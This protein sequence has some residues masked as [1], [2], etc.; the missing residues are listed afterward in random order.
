M[1]WKKLILAVA[2]T[3]FFLAEGDALAQYYSGHSFGIRL[4]NEIAADYK[5]DF[6]THSGLDVKVGV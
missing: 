3:V 5:Y 1:P 4:G 2:A 6:T